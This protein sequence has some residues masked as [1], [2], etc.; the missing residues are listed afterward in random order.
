MVRKHA[1]PLN[2]PRKMRKA[3]PAAPKPSKKDARRAKESVRLRD[4]LLTL[5][6]ILQE[7]QEHYSVR[8]NGLLAQ[9]TQVVDP[10]ADAR[11]RLP[12]AADREHRG[13][14]VHSQPHRV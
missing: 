7:V 2:P 9:M 13:A 12:L 3:P 10:P 4:A 14:Q 8:T 1:S 5:G 6:S 11:E